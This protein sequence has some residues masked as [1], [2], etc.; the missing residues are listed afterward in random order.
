MRLIDADLAM[1]QIKKIRL[2]ESG[3]M[4]VLLCLSSVPTIAP[5]PND[6]LTLEDL[7]EMYGEPVYDW[8][9]YEWFVILEVTEDDVIMTD[10]TVFDIDEESPNN[11][12]GRF[13]RRKPEDKI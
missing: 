4:A 1:E 13:C 11:A 12:D 7:R 9:G 5:P 2:I 3:K 6:Q 8:M 10:G